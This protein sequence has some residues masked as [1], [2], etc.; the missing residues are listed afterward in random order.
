MTIT[1][2]YDIIL[3]MEEEIKEKS[4]QITIVK[5]MHEYISAHDIK[6]YELARKLG[7]TESNV[8]NWLNGNHK[9]S[10]AWQ[11]LIKQR[12]GIG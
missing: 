11:E 9:P 2:F 3:N 6:R 5:K 7:T 12:L 10:K 8:S 1:L 4:Q